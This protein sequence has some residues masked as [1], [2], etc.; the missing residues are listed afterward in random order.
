MS[1]R[2]FLQSLQFGLGATAATALLLED[3][4]LL[5]DE[6]SGV[7]AEAADPAPQAA[8]AVLCEIFGDGA[9]A[10]PRDRGGLA[11]LAR[12]WRGHR[13]GLLALRSEVAEGLLW[14]AR[15]V[16]GVDDLAHWK[17]CWAVAPV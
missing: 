17:A 3:K 12:S 16:A 5:A 2:G 1:R 14:R 8:Q 13:Y 11:R 10:R 9:A 6:E 4:A 7:P 15:R